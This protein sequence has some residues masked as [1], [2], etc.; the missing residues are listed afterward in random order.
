MRASL[1][2]LRVLLAKDL[3]R[4]LRNPVPFLIHL[5]LPL[6]ITGLLGL[7]FAGAGSRDGAGLGRIKIAI[8]DE[9]D[10]IATR[11][12]RGALHQ[13]QAARFI[14]AE[15]LPQDEALRRVTNNA[16][17][18]AVLVPAGFLREYLAGDQQ[19]ALTVVKNPAQMFHPALV[20]EG[21][22]A[23]TT[24]LNALARNL[25]PD[26][27]AWRTLL[28]T[29]RAPS[30]REIGDLA[31]RSGEKLDLLRRRL[32]PIPV[33]YVRETN[34]PAP[35]LAT[36]PPGRPA[37]ARGDFNLFAF[38]LPGLT[39]MFLLFLADVAMRDLHREVR[40]RTFDRFRTLPPGIPLF[41]ASKVLFTFAILAIGC[42]V[43]LGL[44]SALFQFRWQNPAAVIAL[45]AGLSCFSGG[46]MA[47]LNA[48]L[49]GEK[50]SDVLNNMVGMGLG[51][52]GGCAFPAESLPRVLREHVTPL[53]PPHWFV[54]A[55]RAAQFGG[56]SG[57]SWPQQALAMAALGAVLTLAAAWLLRR[58]L[59]KGVRP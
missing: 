2:I 3:R 45:A 15:F 42:L 52:A 23:V 29:N 50:K 30:F 51:M 19:L 59:E 32:D 49:G 56:P 43:L 18:A 26:F 55:M 8:V 12:L 33:V 7:V 17:A 54:E 6:V 24:A 57:G 4:A 9:D 28:A 41:V 13:E 20:E 48:W 10:S 46:L 38:L 47:A 22:G 16:V 37:P 5:G 21:L 40:F 31:M 11:A 27:A 25:R 14:D 34:A 1:A 35:A 39:A 53:L 44:G 58:R 36:D